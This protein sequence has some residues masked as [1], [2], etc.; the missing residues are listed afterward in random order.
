M[1]PTEYETREE[2]IDRY[3]SADFVHAIV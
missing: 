3:R 1:W 2:I